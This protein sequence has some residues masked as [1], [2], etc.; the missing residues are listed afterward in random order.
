MDGS[1][2]IW[3]EAHEK[4]SKSGGAEGE[5]E[6]ARQEDSQPEGEGGRSAGLERGGRDDV[7]ADQET[8]D[9][10]AGCGCGGVVQSAGERLPDA[11]QQYLATGDERGKEEVGS[12]RQMD[13]RKISPH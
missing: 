4:E 7:Q 11:D 9:A 2:R 3:R 5:W 1:I 6:N 13:G 10:A 12:C 8:G